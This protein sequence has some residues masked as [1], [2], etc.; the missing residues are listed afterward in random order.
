[1]ADQLVIENEKA[2][3]T[4]DEGAK[5]ERPAGDI[6]EMFRKE[7]LPPLNGSAYPDGLKFLEWRDPFLL[8]VHQRPWQVLSLRWIAN[9]SPAEFGPDVTYRR[10]RVS[11]P[12]SITF[13][14]FF[15]R[16]GQLQLTDANELYF[17]NAPLT[18]KEDRLGFPG[19]YNISRIAV[20]KREKAW[21]CTQY[22]RREPGMSWTQQL[23]ALLDHTWNGG[24]NRSSE[25][26]EGASWYQLSEGIHADLHP[27]ESWEKATAENEAFGVSVDWKEAPMNVGELMDCMLEEQCAGAMAAL[28]HEMPTTKPAGIVS[29]FM[30]FAQ[31]GSGKEKGMSA[32]AKRMSKLKQML[33]AAK[34]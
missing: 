14:M 16:G 11:V 23:S 26:H 30:N 4:T 10:V 1:M 5:I 21:I 2:V 6:T 15:C 29:R 20:P 7:L 33:A 27:V 25:H 34:Q 13:A 19:V 22:L 24:F 17:R 8:A 32:R 12:Y 31:R 9:D 3:L 28:E 18:S